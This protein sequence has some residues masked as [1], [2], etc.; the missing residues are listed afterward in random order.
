[1][2]IVSK[3]SILLLVCLLAACNTWDDDE[4]LRNNASNEDLYQLCQSTSELST[5]TTVLQKTGY[6]KYLQN[7]HSLTIFAPNNDAL[8]NLNLDNM[9]ELN[10]WIRDYIACLLYYVNADGNFDTENIRMINDKNVPV[11]NNTI[12]GATIVKSNISGRNGVIHIIDATIIPR[13][14]IW[15]YIKEQSGYKQVSFIQ[16]EFRQV[17][18]INRSVQK[19]VDAIGRPI[20][21]T[22]WTTQN[23]FL[24]KFPVDNEKQNFTVILLDDE[25]YDLLKIKYTKY[26]YQKNAVE[27][28]REILKQITG[29]LVLKNVK[30]NAVGRY[31]SIN[32]VLVNIDPTNIKESY[33]ASNGMVYKLS[34]AEIKLY[35]NKIKE[36][37]IDANDYVERY[38][39]DPWIERYKPWAL[40]GNDIVLKGVTVF[41]HDYIRRLFALNG[42]DSLIY[43]NQSSGSFRYDGDSRTNTINCYLKYEPTLYSTNY[44]IAWNAYDDVAS[45]LIGMRIDKGYNNDKIRIY[46]TIPMALHQKLMLSFPGESVVKRTADGYI[47]N[48]FSAF[49]CMGGIDSAGIFTETILKRYK[50][51]VN[52]TEATSNFVLGAPATLWTE[53]D[54]YGQGSS[55]ICP[56]YG[57]AT[58]LVTN[59]FVR[60]SYPGLMFLNYIKIKPIVDPND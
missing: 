9:E 11:G 37:I 18:D 56:A 50:K 60:T 6:D 36:Q 3:I 13:K 25:A 5:F 38:P 8:V 58:F 39:Q 24:T 17:M 43:V 19:G 30:I 14:S 52:E 57:K 27:M 55:I 45:H 12:S 44:E 22:I 28:E 35:Q 51:A 42:S 4:K 2:K 34:A 48:N 47:A 40:G 33:Q 41:N 1:M 54:V 21:D 26:F 49:T 32:D 7:E 59:T 20:Y 16:S 15:E 46:D 31:P 23:D 29:D 10:V 53:A